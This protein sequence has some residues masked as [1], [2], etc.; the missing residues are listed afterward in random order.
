VQQGSVM[1][2]QC[3][4]SSLQVGCCSGTAKAVDMQNRIAHPTLPR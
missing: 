4:L 3:L 1:F 2:V